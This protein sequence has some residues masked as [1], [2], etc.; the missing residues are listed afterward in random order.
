MIRTIIFD[1]GNVVG[2]FDHWRT[3]H[4][5]APFSAIAPEDILEQVYLGELGEPFESGQL[6][7]EEFCQRFRQRC[8]LT[9]DDDFLINAIADIFWPNPD[10]CNL[11][12]QLKGGYRLLLGSNTNEIHANHFLNQFADTLAHFDELVL[13]H[14]IGARKPRAAFFEECLQRAQCA[15][16]ECLFID[17]IPENIQ[18]A[19]R[20]GM[21]GVVYIPHSQLSLHLRT[22]GIA[23]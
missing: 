20:C 12:P 22:L 21:Q 9:C 15:P 18:G 4:R 13:S 3:L 11:V 6:T 19:R 8:S 17:D 23:V 10:I 1:F 2:F 5:L 14:R 16:A 7:V